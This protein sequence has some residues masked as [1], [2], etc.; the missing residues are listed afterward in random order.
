[1]AA[2]TVLKLKFG[3]ANG[4]KTFSFKYAKTNASVESIQNLANVMIENGSIY[5]YPPLTKVS[6]T[7]ETTTVADIALH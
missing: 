3:T 4:E 1:M 6:A 7:L 5:Q 2:G